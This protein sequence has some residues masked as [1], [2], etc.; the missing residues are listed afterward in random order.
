MKPPQSHG[1]GP[2]F[3]VSS[4]GVRLI[5]A[6]PNTKPAKELVPD[7]VAA[8]KKLKLLWVSCGKKDDHG[9][10]SLE[11]GIDNFTDRGRARTS[12]CKVGGYG[13]GRSTR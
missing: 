7:P 5:S 13:D 11:G 12:R 9:D 8:K 10:S 4:Q 1:L 6:A 2:T 3:Q